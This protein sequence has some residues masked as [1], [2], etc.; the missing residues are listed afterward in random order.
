MLRRFIFGGDRRVHPP[1]DLNHPHVLPRC[2][3]DFT[4]S[5]YDHASD[6]IP[7]IKDLPGK[8]SVYQKC[9]FLL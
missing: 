5:V 9:E 7:I 1:Q 6:V 3:A 4:T 2:N 8:N